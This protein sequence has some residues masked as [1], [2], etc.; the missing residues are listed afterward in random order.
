MPHC[1]PSEA[2]MAV[3][4]CQKISTTPATP[5]TP[6]SATRRDIGTPRHARASTRLT[7]GDAA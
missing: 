6:P 2:R 3:N 1:T 7:S 5:A 4:S